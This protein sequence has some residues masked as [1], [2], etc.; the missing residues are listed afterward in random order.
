M[1]TKHDWPLAVTIAVYT[2]AVM[3]AGMAVYA[4][5]QY[6]L[7]PG[8]T[9]MGLAVEHLSH[10]LVLG[11]LIYVMLYLV[12]HRKV[13]RPINTLSWKLYSF[14]GGDFRP[15]SIHSNIREINQIADG[16][17]I[18]L[19]KIDQARPE[20]SLD[21]LARGAGQLRDLVQRSGQLGQQTTEVLL[22]VAKKIDNAVAAITVYTLDEEAG[23]KAKAF[24]DQTG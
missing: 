8:H 13:V 20:V 19:S 1:T 16:I 10:I 24:A 3:V 2:A 9:V 6:F 11:V 14:A 21:D 22:D 17:N 7:S 4:V 18:M 12:L 5:F 23:A 15:T